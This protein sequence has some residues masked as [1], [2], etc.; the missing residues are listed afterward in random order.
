MKH[1]DFPV[2]HYVRNLR[3]LTGWLPFLPPGMER[4]AESLHAVEAEGA[5]L[6][7]FR[8]RSPSRRL[9]LGDP[10]VIWYIAMENHHVSWEN[11]P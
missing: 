11:S 1:G 2:L 4:S 9:G 10:P 7:A 3:R 8:P 6:E 5:D